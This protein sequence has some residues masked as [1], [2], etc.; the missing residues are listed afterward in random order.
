MVVTCRNMQNQKENQVTTINEC[1]I[2]TP[3]IQQLEYP[4]NYN[5]ITQ[6]QQKDQLLIQ[7]FH[8]DARQFKTKI[9]NN[10]NIIMHIKNNSEEKI[11]IPEKLLE[12][13]IFRYHFT[14]MHAGQN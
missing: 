8:N 4:L 13:I 10:N 3:S 5:L 9:F 12:P 11:C 2:N 6:S 14:L 1:L 7:A